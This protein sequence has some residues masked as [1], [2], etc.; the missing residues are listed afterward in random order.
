VWIYLTLPAI[1]G[2]VFLAARLKHP[3]P[4]SRLAPDGGELLD[5]MQA[6]C[7]DLGRHGH[8]VRWRPAGPEAIGGV[9]RWCSGGL[10]ITSTPGGPCI[11]ADPALASPAGDPLACTSAPPR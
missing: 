4:G 2:T 5:I 10:L 11:E 3:E 7:T 9:C 1:A 6:V 8:S